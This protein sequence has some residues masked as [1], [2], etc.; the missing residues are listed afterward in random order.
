MTNRNKVSIMFVINYIKR[1][2]GG[3]LMLKI[4]LKKTKALSYTINKKCL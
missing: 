3:T 2:K 1:N 4:K